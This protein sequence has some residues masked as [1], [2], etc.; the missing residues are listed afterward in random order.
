[1]TQDSSVELEILP[2]HD[3]NGNQ[4]E[5]IQ[6]RGSRIERKRENRENNPT[7]APLLSP[8]LGLLRYTRFSIPLLVIL[9][10]PF[11]PQQNW[12]PPCLSSHQPM[13]G[14]LSIQHSDSIDLPPG[15]VVQSCCGNMSR[16]IGHVTNN[17][18]YTFCMLQILQILLK[19]QPLPAVNP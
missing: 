12:P 15:N 8:D 13:A 9:F 17:P 6:N 16:D 3:F 5:N 19:C 7:V 2:N 4:D 14:N 18:H 11:Y 10:F 1:M